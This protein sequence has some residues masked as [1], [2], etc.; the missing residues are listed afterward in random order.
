MSQ[1]SL[2]QDEN[3]S[4]KLQHQLLPRD[5]LRTDLYFSLPVDMGINPSTLE[6]EDYFHSSIKTQCA[7]YSDQLH[8]PLVRSRFISQQKGEQA[9]YR[10]NLNLFCYQIKIALDIDIKQALKIK[11]PDPFYQTALEICEQTESLLKKLRRYTPPDKKLS[12]FFETADNYLSWHVEQ[13][14]L[15]LLADGPKSYEHAAIR[16]K[17]FEFCAQ[18]QQYRDTNLYNTT[19]TLADPNRITNKM[20][21]LQRLIEYGVVFQKETSNLNNNLR[22][23]VKGVVTAV[24]MA[25]VMTLVLNA[26]SNFAEVTFM[27]VALLGVIYGLREIFKDDLTQLIWRWIQKGRPKWE[28]LYSNS[29]SQTRMVEQTIWLEYIRAKDLPPLADAL[30]QKRRQQNKQDSQLLHF[31]CDSK[32]VTKEFYSGYDEIQQEISFNLTP[33]VRYLKKGEG[34][35]YSAENKKISKQAVERR[36]QVN[37]VVIQTDKKKVSVSQRFK[38]TLN[39]SEIVN[40]EA[41]VDSDVDGIASVG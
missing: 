15:N 19:V 26:R 30:L 5:F 6:E 20:R 13:S 10:L 17:L 34:K 38:I 24:M 2:I 12:P 16:D 32:V 8:L 31:R 22:R 1:I 25:F 21:L 9:D 33:L 4:L 3:L 18:E 28:N 29:A 36:Y 37:L 23:L 7:Y 41:M 35:L 39:R 27:L 11:E 14:F 40:I